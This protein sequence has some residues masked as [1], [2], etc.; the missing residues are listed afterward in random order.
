MGLIRD[1]IYT[2][3]SFFRYQV[4]KSFIYHDL[5]VIFLSCIYDAY[6]I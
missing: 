1:G 3:V 2:N 4:W 5:M 6:Y